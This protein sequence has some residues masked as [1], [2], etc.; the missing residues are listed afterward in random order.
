MTT[1]SP[2]YN[3]AAFCRRMIGRDCLAVM[4]AASAEA[5]L[6]QRTHRERTGRGT[7][8][9][10]SRG[11]QY[12]D[13]LQQLISMLMNGSVPPDVSPEF[14]W[15]A[16][17][18]VDDLLLRWEIGD[19]RAVFTWVKPPTVAP[20]WLE[21]VDPLTVVAS[22]EQ[23]L[24]RDTG[25]LAQVLRGLTASREQALRWRERVEFRVQGWDGRTEALFENPD[26]RRFVYELD[27]IFP[28]WL[29]FLSKNSDSLKF[30]TLCFLPPYLTAEGRAHE[31]PQRLGQLLSSRWFP[32]MN[33][34]CAWVGMSEREIE[35][36]TNRVVV[37][38]RA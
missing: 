10:G 29:F 31:F 25:D 22:R 30:L 23:V 21:G 35:A 16:K 32:A 37:Y 5:A 2:D 4:D 19:L 15:A 6:A 28:Y 11:R 3:F 33:Q 7:F 26:I 12:C 8:R 1:T 36:M 27:E 34:L 13:D 9:T 18:L 14:L 24:A 20:G 38:L 17:P